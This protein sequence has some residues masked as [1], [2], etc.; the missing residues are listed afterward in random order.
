M[1][2]DI[3]SFF[4][5]VFKKPKKTAET[6]SVLP[7]KFYTIDLI[8]KGTQEYWVVS[9]KEK[10][11]ADFEFEEKALVYCWQHW[12]RFNSPKIKDTVYNGF[13]DV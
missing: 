2:K 4:K 12:K 9:F 8:K 11:V 1:L 5:G 6:A 3:Y 7:A 10:I 13:I